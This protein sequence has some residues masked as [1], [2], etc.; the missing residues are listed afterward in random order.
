M[1]PQSLM[2]ITRQGLWLVVMLSSL[3]IGPSLIVGLI[4]SVFQT[5]TSINE[6]T[7][8]FLPRLIV[9][10][11]VIVVGGPWI[12]ERLMDFTQQIFTNI[13]YLIG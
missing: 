12:M 2:E 9:T 5:A 3:I 1:E 11:V 7:L 13:P 10:V 6:Q 4:V 8:S